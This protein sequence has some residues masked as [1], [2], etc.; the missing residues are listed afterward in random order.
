MLANMD[1][2]KNSIIRTMVIAAAV[3]ILL[4]FIFG[5]YPLKDVFF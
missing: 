3:F 4:L 5:S 1:E 2:D